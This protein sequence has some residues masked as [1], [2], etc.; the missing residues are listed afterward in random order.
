MELDYPLS[1]QFVDGW[2]K[3]DNYLLDKEQH[4]GFRKLFSRRRDHNCGIGKRNS[5]SFLLI[6]EVQGVNG[7]F[8]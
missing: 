5:N 1:E 6:Q 3:T 2:K 7:R 4:N 8:V